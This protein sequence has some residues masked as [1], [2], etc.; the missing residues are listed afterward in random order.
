MNKF[1]RAGIADGVQ[2]F[3]MARTKKLLAEEYTESKDTEAEGGE[4]GI[5]LRR[6]FREVAK[7]L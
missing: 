4:K 5:G 2:T 6:H 7:I 1:A 3:R